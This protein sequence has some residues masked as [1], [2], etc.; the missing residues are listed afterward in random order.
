M[1]E[2][3][4]TYGLSAQFLGVVLACLIRDRVG[5][6]PRQAPNMGLVGTAIVMAGAATVFVVMHRARCGRLGERARPHIRSRRGN[7]PAAPRPEVRE[8]LT[9]RTV[10]AVDLGA[11]RS[12][13][14]WRRNDRRKGETSASD[15][16]NDYPIPMVR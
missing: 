10:T 14:R 15:N 1:T 11:R 4:S 13:F 2:L 9:L 5:P 3:V 7:G 12:T 8:A 16:A 6:S